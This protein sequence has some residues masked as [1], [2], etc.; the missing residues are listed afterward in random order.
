MMKLLRLLMI[1]VCLLGGCD[2]LFA[3]TGKLFTTDRELSSSMTTHL[4]QD[5]DGNIWIST[6]YGLNRY[7]AA[8]FRVYQHEA[9]NPHSLV[10]SFVNMTFQRSTGEIFV[11]TMSGLCLYDP[12]TD[13]FLRIPMLDDK[14]NP[15]TSIY[16]ARIIELPD[17]ELLVGTGGHGLYRLQK[18]GQGYTGV[19]TLQTKIPAQYIYGMLSDS[20]GRLWVGGRDGEVYLYDNGRTA[21]TQ[22]DAST[23]ASAVASCFCEDNRGRII[24]G[25]HGRGVYA[26]DEARKAF[27]RM[28]AEQIGSSFVHALYTDASGDVL[29]GTDGDGLWVIDSD[30]G[31]VYAAPYYADR[32]PLQSSKVFS[33]L[34]DKADYLWA[35][36]YQRGLAV[37]PPS[38]VPFTY[39]G[40]KSPEN[41]F[42]GSN[43]VTSVLKDHTGLVW[44][45]TENDALYQFREDGSVRSRL[46]AKDGIRLSRVTSLYEDSQHDI[47]LGTVDQGLVRYHR[48]T[49]RFSVDYQLTD[50]HGH[51]VNNIARIIEDTDG[52]FYVGT[53]GGG[54]FRISTQS[55]AV[56]RCNEPTDAGLS[57]QS[58]SITNRWITSLLITPDRQLLFGSYFG[59]NCMDL[60]TRTLNAE[61]RNDTILNKEIVLS[62]A[63]TRD[64][65]VY[66]G[67]ENGLI[68]LDGIS[69]QRRYTTRDGL[70][71][72]LI[73]SI[74]VDG[75]G[76]L[77]IGTGHGLSRM[78]ADGHFANYYAGDGL[79]GNEFSPEASFQTAQGQLFFGGLNGL[80]AFFADAISSHA[81]VP[82]VRVTDFYLNGQ[83]MPSLR[84]SDTFRLAHDDNTFTIE[85]ATDEYFSPERIRYS[86]SVNGNDFILLPPGI[87][88]VTLSNL[89]PDTYQLRVVAHD[90][91]QQ[92]EPREITVI[93]DPAWYAS[94]WARLIYTLLLLS[95]ILLTVYY[96]RQRYRQQER[97]RERARKEQE[98]EA[99][100]KF[101]MNISHE[102]RTPMSM[103]I[104]PATQLMETDEEPH[105]RQQYDVI[106][107]NAQRI[108]RLITQM[109]DVRKIEKGQMS[110]QLQPTQLSPLVEELCLSM[111]YAAGQKNIGL[112][113]HS[114]YPDAWANIDPNYFDKILLNLLSNA[115][116]FTP[117]GG[118]IS[119]LLQQTAEG[120]IALAVTDNGIGISDEN[121]LHIFDR[122]YQIRNS[123]N[124]A[125][126]GTGIGLNL[127]YS[128]A[129]MHGGTLRVAD[130]PEGQGASFILT[131]PA[132]KAEGSE[133]S[134]VKSEKSAAIPIPEPSS[135][136]RSHSTRYRLLLVD[137]DPE[138][139]QYVSRELADTYHVQTANNGREAW[140]LVINQKTS[141]PSKTRL[142]V[143][144]DLVLTDVMMPEMDGIE[145]CRKIKQNI[146]VNSIPVVMLTAMTDEDNHLHSL[147]IGADGYITKP[148]S[149]P[150][151]RQTLTNVLRNRSLLQNYFEGNQQQA[152]AIDITGIKQEVSPDEKLMTRV[153]QVVEKHISDP[154]L[155]VE[156]IAQE[157]GLSR[158]HLYRKLKDLTNQSP[159]DFVRNIR[160]QKAAELL[161]EGHFNVAEI[162]TR[163]GF[164][165]H[166][167]FSRAFKDFFGVSPKEYGAS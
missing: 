127:A 159:S 7:D 138:I 107:R 80:S 96:L 117:E 71:S 4:M 149:L 126:P 85:F 76:H 52:I 148:F 91:D 143:A 146:Q 142:P 120:Q 58:P 95:L 139:R 24:I 75:H 78:S 144:F 103:I 128:L 145:L 163:M 99:K 20:K 8:K 112:T 105:R 62:L 29:V 98:N 113:F 152:D 23:P 3:Q 164:S 136:N 19:P 31:R 100:L 67:T 33:V 26:Y 63:M 106:L 28:G 110:L 49:G 55:H 69:L 101:L 79:Q 92:S 10:S 87:H 82:R 116:K 42:I 135:P 5:R 158:V 1:L 166:S 48:A 22:V 70:P 108:M 68:R 45:G 114:L 54:L 12:Q 156:F 11:A 104:S 36:V 21:V 17:H 161:K 111:D 6:E 18:N 34:R 41:G 16:I 53:A 44:V 25:T 130:N 39:Y 132:C 97:E 30:A 86:Y 46:A 129:Q 72:D 47:W 73:R 50:K 88:S 140:D 93:V 151:L 27:V 94:W 35:C 125:Q 77:W 102:L 81:K 89:P 131:L 119:V 109:L 124:S 123:I 66:A 133:K 64:G 153:L 40:Y 9:D 51:T 38:S 134:E 14:G 121:K 155:N 122:F 90:L 83:P 37:F 15:Y 154:K 157:A 150:L 137:D 59:L 57:D 65:V 43:S 147:N 167:V 74:E 60:N 165:S 160:L 32:Q 84:G 118:H 141:F 61:L 56:E 2:S 162:S 13:A 115:I